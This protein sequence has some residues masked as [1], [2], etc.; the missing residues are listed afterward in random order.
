MTGK[1]LWSSKVG[2]ASRRRRKAITIKVKMDVLGRYERG[3]RTADIKCALGLSES[4]LRTIR[5]SAEKIKESARCGTSVSATKTSYARSSI[6]E[7]MERML[8]TWIEHQNQENVPVGMLVI[9]AKA[10]SI[11]EDLINDEGEVKPFNAS[12]GWF[13]NF[14]NRYNYHNIKM[15]GEAVAADTVAAEKF[16]A[17]LKAIIE[18][19]GYS[20]KQIFNVDETG[21]FWK[22][23]PRRTYISREEK[24]VPGFKAA[25][26][27]FTLL[28]GGN[29]EGDCK[30]KPLMV[31]HSENPKA[32]KGYVKKCL[33]VYWYSNAKGC[34]TGKIF[35]EYFSSQLHTELKEYCEKENLSFK[36]LILLDDAIGHPPS[37]QDLSE[38]IKVVFLPP[39]TTSLIQ[40]MDQG[41]IATFKTYY[42]RRTFANLVKS[43]DNDHM[44]VKEFWKSF[45]IRDA[46]RNVEESWKEV[47]PYCMN[48]VW[49][50]LCPQFVN[51]FKGFSVNNDLLKARRN[52]VEMAKTVGFDE[53]KEGDVE[54]LL[55]SYRE[56]LSNEDLLLLEKE[57]QVEESEVE[58][59]EV[60]PLRT[61]TCKRMAEAF[62]LIDMG[63]TIFDEDDPNTERSSRVARNVQ[64][65]L[66]RYKLIQKEKR[67]KATQMTFFSFF[68]KSEG[69][70]HPKDDASEPST[71]SGQR[72]I[73]S[74]I[75]PASPLAA[76]TR[77]QQQH[78]IS[79]RC[80][81]DQVISG[82]KQRAN[83]LEYTSFADG[84]TAV[85]LGDSSA[86]RRSRVGSPEDKESG[87]DVI[88]KVKVKS[89]FVDDS[90]SQ[91]EGEAH[92]MKTENFQRNFLQTSQDALNNEG[93]KQEPCDS[94][95]MELSNATQMLTENQMGVSVNQHGNF[96]HDTDKSSM[97]SENTHTILT[98]SSKTLDEIQRNEKP[99]NFSF[100][101]K[102]LP[103]FSSPKRDQNVHK[104]EKS[105]TCPVCSQAFYN[106][107]SLNKHQRTHKREKPY[108][109]SLCQK[110]F[111]QL[112]Y[113]K[114]HQTTCTG[115]KPYKCSVCN[116]GYDYSSS[117][118][119]HRII[120]TKEKPFSCSVCSKTFGYSSTLSQH[121]IVHSGKK[122]YKC[123]VCTKA[124]TY[125]SS[126][127]R[128][129]KLHTGEKPYRCSVCSK[130][131]AL[132]SQVKIHERMHMGEK[133][134]K[135]SV[136]LNAFSSFS[137]LKIHRRIHTE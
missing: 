47:T 100:S 68:Q 43:T 125:L 127:Y 99:N 51:G 73:P 7:K 70:E 21:L 16:P 106:I 87:P 39:N 123:S 61:L 93:V 65:E 113:L 17:F 82:E 46:L 67:M 80:S 122:P 55:D 108:T 74:P 102:T 9:Q 18:E 77:H 33:P 4:T 88:V 107:S 27:R 20:P 1:R 30:L 41:V 129:Q 10:R 45:T 31:Y 95:S 5:N 83:P 2:S 98:R 56:E 111:V 35:C 22:R 34:I 48:G 92:L 118:S 52:I 60:E 79:V 132:L 81:M 62:R 71:S 124:F 134:H 91:D 94:P 96:C 54:E 25:K 72:L 53:V 36:I 11:Y 131:F 115:E 97:S 14:R 50:K 13:S 29:V 116:K 58:S 42:L 69:K 85:S 19:G 8:S 76:T 112:I 37:I 49:G 90:F 86:E 126:Y 44:T 38:N 133:P 109:C 84:G 23:M 101:T 24:T 75:Q 110:A 130:P 128:H 105:F 136:C 66:S 78:P 40:P 32:L 120:H 3:D 103:S 28:L 26:D 117:L 137:K 104:D 6:M 135:C 119:I 59:E 114:N 57:R 12:S 63:L 121:Q 89:E 64:A 15:T